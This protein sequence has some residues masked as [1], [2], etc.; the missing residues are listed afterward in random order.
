MS[1][2]K[3]EKRHKKLSGQIRENEERRA[4][5]VERTKPL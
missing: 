1:K 2:L 3:T 4:K 5:E